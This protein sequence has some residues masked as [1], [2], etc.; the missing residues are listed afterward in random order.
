MGVLYSRREIV[1]DPIHQVQTRKHK[2]LHSV[3]KVDTK[4]FPHFETTTPF[5]FFFFTIHKKK[6]PIYLARR[7]RL[8]TD[9]GGDVTEINGN[10]SIRFSSE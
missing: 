8:R 7:I 2:L 10:R 9:F 6:I 5:C 4:S 1:Q 3:G